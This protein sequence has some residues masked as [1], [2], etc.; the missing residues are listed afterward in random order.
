MVGGTATRAE[1]S[2]EHHFDEPYQ[3][4]R[5]REV[6]SSSTGLTSVRYSR[7]VYFPDLSWRINLSNIAGETVKAGGPG[8]ANLFAP[9][10]RYDGYFLDEG[11]GISS[12]TMGTAWPQD[13][14]K[15]GLTGR[16]GAD[17]DVGKC[18]LLDATQ[19]ALY[20]FDYLDDLEVMGE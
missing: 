8:T 13:E 2:N 7:S 9:G 4:D 17:D 15:R 11:D 6:T 19:R 12:V 18:V 10:F 20:S 16:L 3:C 5:G 14:S 1:A